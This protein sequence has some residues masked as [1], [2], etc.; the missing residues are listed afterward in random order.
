MTTIWPLDPDPVELLLLALLA[1][2]ALAALPVL[3]VPPPPPPLLPVPVTCWPTERS[4]DATVPEM[5]D[6]KDASFSAV[7]AL[8]SDDSAEV[9]EAWSE[10]TCVALAPDASSLARRASAESS[11]AWSAF[12]SSDSAVVSTV[13]S[14]SPAVT[15]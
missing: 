10:S 3:P 15:V 13:A 12:R 7:C 5:V 6:V 2:A 8:V 11:W 4:T 1:L 9:T 14:T